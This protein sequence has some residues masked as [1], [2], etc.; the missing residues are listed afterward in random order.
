M[1]DLHTKHPFIC[2]CHLMTIFADVFP[3]FSA[4]F[5][6][7]GWFKTSYP[8]V[9]G[10]EVR[11]P[12]FNHGRSA[13]PRWSGPLNKYISLNSGLQFTWIC[14]SPVVEGRF[15]DFRSPNNRIWSFGTPCHP[16]IGRK[17][18]ENIGKHCHQMAFA[19]EWVPCLQINYTIKVLV[20]KGC[21][22]LSW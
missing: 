15:S 8:V 12:S 3:Y 5:R 22:I 10:P 18:W 1:T 6:I 11:E 20:R 4:S 19:N 9:G 13:D 14:R 21:V 17:I 16:K 2:K 7:I